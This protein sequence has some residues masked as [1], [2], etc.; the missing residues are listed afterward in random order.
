MSEI[1]LAEITSL[2]AARF[3]DWLLT[4]IVPLGRGRRWTTFQA[5]TKLRCGAEHDWANP[6][7][8]VTIRARAAE[9]EPRH[10]SHQ[11]T[12]ASS[13][14]EGSYDKDHWIE[15]YPYVDGATPADQ[16][17][18]L[19]SYLSSLITT[20]RT[21]HRGAASK[22]SHY[23]FTTRWWMREV[24]SALLDATSYLHQHRVVPYEMSIEVMAYGS[25]ALGMVSPV[26]TSLLHGDLSPRNL[27]LRR[28]DPSQVA[29]LI[30]WDD[31]RLGDY[32]WDLSW[33]LCFHDQDDPGL[34]E[35][36]LREYHG[37][38]VDEAMPPAL[39]LRFWTY[40][41][42]DAVTRL[43]TH[44]RRDPKLDFTRGTTRL[45]KALNELTRLV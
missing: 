5:Q 1:T 20:L 8:V 22:A 36:T 15:L 2:C 45:R 16:G 38:G 30:D 11:S 40:Y 28:D 18:P 29:G 10:A 13:M 21:T 7:R 33:L 41:L 25:G 9:G 37:L 43:R 35:R 24:E 34:P 23:P 39:W 19:G 3:K 17:A 12:Q 26:Q 44:H 14:L 6:V 4:D 31:A 32:L 42:V 27:L